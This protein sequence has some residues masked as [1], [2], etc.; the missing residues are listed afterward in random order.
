M[1][2]DINP[3]IGAGAEA[4]ALCRSYRFSSS[5]YNEMCAQ[6]G[7]LRPHWEYVGRTLDALGLQELQRR[8]DEARRLLRD[9]DVTY[10]VYT[11]PKGIGRPWD[12]DLIPQLIE[13]EEW[14]RIE[15]GLIQ[16]AELLNLLLADI[17][18]PRK[19]IEK[20]II[21][22]ELIYAYPAFL[23]PC[24]GITRQDNRYLHMY[25]AD[26][27]RSPD[28]SICVIAD[29]TQA[30]SGAGY[31]LENRIVLSR[32]FPSL[33]RDSHVHRLAP[34]FRTMRNTLNSLAVDPE[35]DPRI[36]LLSPGVGNESYFEHAYLANYLGYTLVQGGDLTVRD[37]RVWLKTLNKLQRVDVILRR[38]DEEYC[39]PL[40]LR[41][42]S[43]LG[44]PG[45]L[46]VVR[47]GNVTIAN[48]L[49][50]G[51]LQNPALFAFMQ[52]LSR[53][54]H[55]EDLRLANAKTWWCG[56]EKDLN[57]VIANLDRLI[58]KPYI[59]K[60]ISQRSIFGSELD[61]KQRANLIDEIRLRPY[62]YTAQ[63]QVPL[64]V[65]PVLSG[66][67]FID[68]RQVLLRS[69][70][71]AQDE[72]YMVM[73]GGLTR[74]SSTAE[75]YL[76]T[77]QQ[78]GASKDTW[79]LASEPE[80]Q[81]TLIVPATQTAYSMRRSGDVPSRV[82]D[83]LFWLGR[84]AER[85]EGI[86]RLLRIIQL[87]LADSPSTTNASLPGTILRTLLGALTQCTRLY[88]GFTGEDA[89]QKLIAPEKEL[90]SMIS[91]GN[92]HGSLAQTLS[93]L[94][95]TART[96]RDRLSGDTLRVI[97]DIDMELGS[98]QYS[99]LQHLNDADD[100][101]D[102][103][104]TAL[105][106]LSGLVNENMTHEQGWR[107]LEIGRRLERALHTSTL[108]RATLVQVDQFTNESGLLESLLSIIDSLMTY[109]R[110]FIRGFEV[111]PLLDLVLMDEMNP[112][113]IAYQLMSIQQHATHLP[114]DRSRSQM[115]AEE[116]LV[117]EMITKLRLS[118]L[119]SLATYHEPEFQREQLDALLGTMQVQL[120]SLSDILTAAYFQKEEQ[121]HQLV[122]TR[123]GV[124]S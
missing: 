106:G 71:V 74:V 89:E 108:L 92:R 61:E 51:V 9:N 105:V 119:A 30:P 99:D 94:L 70:L 38:V 85:A 18:G 60:N 33:F 115:T 48:P 88:P 84:Y 66:V 20:G 34:F 8:Y 21:P 29:R 19:L 1:P 3:I 13:S 81:E 6:P 12:L 39:D 103:L 55:G 104:I 22:P 124:W 59:P 69:Y 50:S 112:R 113:S 23:H 118:D 79:V 90:I 116:R 54:F 10:N 47:D 43:Y 96:V 16:R 24:D 46:Q 62:L 15:A 14:S 123:H 114:G 72:T 56:T 40:E 41:E 100:E 117:L 101:L 36:V 5:A 63:E 53:Y 121:I 82:A 35:R 111:S 25:S 37:G 77:G 7:E 49:G 68:T 75:S 64:S 73:P 83:N 26:L 4:H 86:V 87:H 42:D 97:N 98:L 32:V 120:Y 110:N 45:L 44:V 107:F 80:K 65:A 28:G 11:D 95:V 52:K 57:H 109:K 58:I 93:A 102:N 2:S 122:R 31:A 91:D 17:Y 78:G 76:I 27:A 67:D